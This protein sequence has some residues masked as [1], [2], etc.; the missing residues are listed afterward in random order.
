MFFFPLNFIVGYIL[1]ILLFVH[2]LAPTLGYESYKSKNDLNLTHCYIHGT[3]YSGNH[4]LKHSIN[5]CEI[6]EWQAILFVTYKSFQSYL[7]DPQD[8]S[9]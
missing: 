6:N 1:F 9:I 4:T 2:C 8:K 7:Q 5:V 3:Y